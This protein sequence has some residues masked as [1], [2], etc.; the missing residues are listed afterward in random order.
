V[1]DRLI[2]SCRDESVVHS[3]EHGVVWVTYEP[4][5]SEAELGILRDIGAS[6]ETI[7]GPLPDQGWAAIGT[8]GVSD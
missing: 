6:R 8:L 7:V 4:R 2:G 1:C 3:L 5:G